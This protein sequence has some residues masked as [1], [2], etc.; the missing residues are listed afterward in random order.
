MYPRIRNRRNRKKENLREII[1]E[2]RLSVDDFILPVFITDQKASLPI[3]SMPG[4]ARHSLDDLP[5]YIKEA[6]LLGVKAVALFPYINI[7][8]KSEGAEEALNPNNL[9]CRAINI[10]KE[11]SPNMVIACDVALDPYTS[12]GHDGLLIDN[13]VNNDKTLEVLGEQALTLVRAGCDIVAP[14]DMMDGRI[15]YIRDLL[16][17][18]N[19]QNINIISYAV[20]YASAFYRPFREAIGTKA[21]LNKKDKKTYQMDFRN[22]KEALIEAALDI[23]EGADIL[24]VKPALAYLDI[25]SDL[26]KNFNTPIFAYQVS[27]EYAMIKSAA[28][29]GLLDYKEVMVE[30]LTSIK[31]AGAKAIFTY[32]AMDMAKWI[33]EGK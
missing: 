31:R 26:N 24:M 13:E 4:I 19:Y 17:S 10:I 16:E 32:A 30:S 9:I 23:Q 5:F 21:T 7:A 25:I 14:S 2:T 20:K 11:C 18:N 12:H 3:I 8:L 28:I 27:G 6:V 1:A 15:G 33:L 22:R 29:N